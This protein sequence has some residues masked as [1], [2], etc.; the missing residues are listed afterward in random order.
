MKPPV[1]LIW[2]LAVIISTGCGSR[3][4]DEM[5]S[6]DE[7]P[8]AV[9]KESEIMS[10]RLL[11][12]AFENEG[13]IPSQYTCQGTEISPPLGWE[14]PPEGTVSFALIA[15]DLIK[16][17]IVTHWV[18]YNIPAASRELPEAIPLKEALEDGTCQ[19]KNWKRNNGYMGPCPVGGKHCYRFTIFA[20]DT[21]VAPN[22]RM[23]KKGLLKLI[24]GHILGSAELV[25]Y[26]AKK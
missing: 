22:P 21:V 7:N 12:P 4:S 11:S 5:K 3:T 24:E 20:L 17:L 15:E 2:I 25:G 6:L 23:N 19:G 8:A 9:N 18:V 26:Y 1:V 13:D 10:F 14:N 16:W